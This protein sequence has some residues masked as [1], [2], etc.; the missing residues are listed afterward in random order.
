[1][2]TSHSVACAR[3]AGAPPVHCVRRLQ[4]A[5][6]DDKDALELYALLKDVC[7]DGQGEQPAAI[8]A[9]R[10]NELD[11]AAARAVTAA[12]DGG[13]AVAESGG[14]HAWWPSAAAA[15]GAHVSEWEG[16][17]SRTER[18]GHVYRLTHSDASR[19]RRGCGSLLRRRALG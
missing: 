17:Y 4:V 1:M 19:W 14:D 8:G 11:K 5:R 13:S 7:G 15:P 10:L 2:P 12:A 18:G 3:V 16:A 6:P 9:R